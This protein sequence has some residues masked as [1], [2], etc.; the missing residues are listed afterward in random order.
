MSNK[1]FVHLVKES[2]IAEFLEKASWKRWD[3]SPKGCI[4]NTSKEKAT[5]K[6]KRLEAFGEEETM[7]KF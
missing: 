3:L 6:S 2:G 7:R 4:G 1:S 5:Y